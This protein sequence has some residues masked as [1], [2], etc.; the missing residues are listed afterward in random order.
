MKQKKS[1][2]III[3]IIILLILILIAGIAF[4]YFSTDL[5]KSNK[6]LFFKYIGQIG[7]SENG[8]IEENINQYFTKKENTPYKNQGELY[9]EISAPDEYKEQVENTNNMNITFD[10]EVDKANSNREENISINYS[11]KVNIDF[12]YKKIQDK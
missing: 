12:I 9:V 1:L 11:D 5:F 4:A 6:Q 8:L 3:L 10:G 2:K 7:N